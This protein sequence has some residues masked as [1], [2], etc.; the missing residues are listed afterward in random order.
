MAGCLK[1]PFFIQ[2]DK[3]IGTAPP[4]VKL[5]FI[6]ATDLVKWKKAT[7]ARVQKQGITLKTAKLGWMV[8]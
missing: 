7:L 8:L 5:A 1:S 6:Q 2:T 3:A 4:T